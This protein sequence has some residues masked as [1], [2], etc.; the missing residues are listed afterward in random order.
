MYKASD[1]LALFL[2]KRGLEMNKDLLKLL[3]DQI[4]MEIHSANLYLNMSAF[5]EDEGLDGM[6]HW[7][8]V[9]HL[10]EMDHAMKIYH[11]IIERGEHAEIGQIDQ[12]ERDFEGVFDVWSRALEHEKMISKAFDEIM[13]LAMEQKEFK[14][15]TMIQ[16]FVDEQ[17]EEEDTFG[18]IKD[19]L[20]FS[21]CS[22][23]VLMQMNAQMATRAYNPL[24][25]GMMPTVGE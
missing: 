19:K 1:E 16:W 18:G 17:V 7:L 6:A 5:F 13:A 25:G 3:N 8:Y 12:P 4:A 11:H 14:S 23:N 24:P 22:K 15:L 10:E 20:E 21:E 2:N 9:Q